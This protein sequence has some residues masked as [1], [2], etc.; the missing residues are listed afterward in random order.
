[1][2]YLNIIPHNE[3]LIFESLAKVS[4]FIHYNEK[5][6]VRTA[7]VTFHLLCLCLTWKIEI[8]Y[9]LDRVKLNCHWCPFLDLQLFLHL[10]FCMIRWM[11]VAVIYNNYVII[12]CCYSMPPVSCLPH[13]TCCE[14]NS[15]V[16]ML[17]CVIID[18]TLWILINA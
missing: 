5:T 12:L 1:M 2:I 11:I 17:Y 14:I 18:H 8:K 16:N 15:Q 10:Y 6:L 4:S 3:L 9:H 13:L 7:L